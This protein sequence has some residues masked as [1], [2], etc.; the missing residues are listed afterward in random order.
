M[1]PSIRKKLALTSLF[2]LLLKGSYQ[3]VDGVNSID[4]HS[5]PSVIYQCLFSQREGMVTSLHQCQKKKKKR[6]SNISFLLYFL[7]G[8]YGK[9]E[10]CV[11]KDKVIL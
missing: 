1:A 10:L 4:R 5:I 8:F 2:F 3:C 7:E 11:T 6:F 9:T